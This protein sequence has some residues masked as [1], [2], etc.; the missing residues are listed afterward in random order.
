MVFGYL[1]IRRATRLNR[2]YQFDGEHFDLET[3]MS[4]ITTLEHE[5][6]ELLH[7]NNLTCDELLTEADVEEQ[8][9]AV[10]L[11][12]LVRKGKVKFT[13]D[14]EAESAVQPVAE[15]SITELPLRLD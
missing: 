1:Q 15:L 12:N 10:A 13:F 2:R 9:L 3:T 5:V 14:P 11:W 7:G 4:A 6:L 8:D